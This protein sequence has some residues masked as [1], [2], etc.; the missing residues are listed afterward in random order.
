M[1][2][3]RR[4]ALT[5][6]VATSA[7]FTLAACAA[8]AEPVETT[9]PSATVDE[10][11]A[12]PTTEQLLGKADDVIVGSGMKYKISDALTILV[13][14]PALETFRAFNA[15]CTH[16]GCI[17]TGVRE[18]Q[19]TCGCHGARFDTDSGEPQSG[20]ARSALGKITIEVRGEDLYA[21]I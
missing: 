6:I 7:A 13:T 17:V 21:L 12:P 1:T 4:T 18:D 3:N 15:T 14:R 9:L 16:A 5:G 11:S 20:P 8:E 19:I 2:V 10:T